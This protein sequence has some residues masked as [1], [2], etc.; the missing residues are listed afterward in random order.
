MAV[1]VSA[2]PVRGA[3]YSRLLTDPGKRVAKRSVIRPALHGLDTM[4]VSTNSDGREACDVMLNIYART[5]LRMDLRPRKSLTFAGEELAF[6]LHTE[7]AHGSMSGL[8]AFSRVVSPATDLAP[9]FK[10]LHA[11]EAPEHAVLKGSEALR[12]DPARI[13]AALEERNPRLTTMRDEEAKVAV[14]GNGPMHVHL[15]KTEIGGSYH[16]GIYVDGFYCPEHGMPETGGHTHGAP[17]EHGAHGASAAD[18]GC[19]PECCPERF[20]RLLTSSAGVVIKGK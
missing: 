20:T 3:R 8:R 12:F 2:G 5:H 1:P 6:D 19:G 9:L 17:G 13:L 14:H 11:H 15:P 4:P 7:L 16:I 10:A 18:N